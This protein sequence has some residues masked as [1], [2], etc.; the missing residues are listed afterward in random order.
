VKTQYSRKE[1]PKE[2]ANTVQLMTKKHLSSTTTYNGP[3]IESRLSENMAKDSLSKFFLNKR[4][5]IN[6]QGLQGTYP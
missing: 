1:Y 2:Y 5:R 6:A 3:L 4:T